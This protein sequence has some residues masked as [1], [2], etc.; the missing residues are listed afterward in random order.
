MHL[1]EMLEIGSSHT[2]AEQPPHI[3]GMPPLFISYMQL[4]TRWISGLA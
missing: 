3:I 4:A 1:Q 2:L